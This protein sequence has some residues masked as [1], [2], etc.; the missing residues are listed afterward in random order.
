MVRGVQGRDV[1][2]NPP[3]SVC[4]S[5]LHAFAYLARKKSP[6]AVRAPPLDLS[7]FLSARS[8]ARSSGFTVSSPNAVVDHARD[9]KT[10]DKHIWPLAMPS[11]RPCVKLL[12][13]SVAA[14]AFFYCPRR[15]VRV[16]FLCR[17]TPTSSERSSASV[18][19]A[20]ASSRLV[21]SALSRV[22]PAVDGSMADASR[23]GSRFVKRGTKGVPSV[24]RKL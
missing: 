1:S 19:F 18:N 24:L 8:M 11:L 2:E 9:K 23:V 17:S 14:R 15:L 21:A 16:C 10:H 5:L 4:T 3:D 13:F 20:P 6:T 7:S 12:P 22:R